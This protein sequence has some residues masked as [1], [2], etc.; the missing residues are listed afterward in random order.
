MDSPAM[1]AESG[2]R[3]GIHH[4]FNPVPVLADLITR[5]EHPEDVGVARESTTPMTKPATFAA[6]FLVR[7]VVGLKSGSLPDKQPKSAETGPM[8]LRVAKRLAANQSTVSHLGRRY[9]F[10]SHLVS[11]FQWCN[12]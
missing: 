11:R 4:P 1:C 12:R 8:R 6:R 2:G 3:P 10:E 7:P 5:G 9:G